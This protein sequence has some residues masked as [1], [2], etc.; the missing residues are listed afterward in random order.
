M[1]SVTAAG[2][3][4]DTEEETTV[5]ISPAIRVLAAQTT[6]KKN[7]VVGKEL[8]FSKEDFSAVLGYSPTE[9]TLTSLPDP[10]KGVLKLGGMTLAPGSRLS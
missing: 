2:V 6:M 4:A 10:T 3:S 7:G 9:V 1:T 8:C 5:C